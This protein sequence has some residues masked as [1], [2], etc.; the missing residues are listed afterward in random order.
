MPCETEI[1]KHAKNSTTECARP[2]IVHCVE[3]R[4]GICSAHIIECEVCNLFLHQHC[5][6]EHYKEHER[7]TR[8]MGNAA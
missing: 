5:A 1:W 4:G 3:C 7:L 8:Q 2:P 6:F